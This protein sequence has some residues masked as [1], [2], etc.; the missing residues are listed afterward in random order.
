M[1]TQP[2][3]C[4]LISREAIIRAT[5]LQDYSASG[6]QPGESFERCVITQTQSQK[7]GAQLSIELHNPSPF[8]VEELESTKRIDKGTDLPAGLGPGFTAR[9][10]GKNGPS[11]YA[12]AWTDDARMMLSIWIVP[13]APGRDPRADAIEFV[14]QLKPILLSTPK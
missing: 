11:T 2:Q 14:R 4:G 13:G 5:G 9:T 7:L 10:E 12:F 3:E 8:T 6:S 1:T